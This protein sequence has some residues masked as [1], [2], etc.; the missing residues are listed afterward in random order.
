[1]ASSSSR[2]ADYRDWAALAKPMAD[3]IQ[4]R[5]GPHRDARLIKAGRHLLIAA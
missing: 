2:N 3:H 5:N 1:L 4:Y